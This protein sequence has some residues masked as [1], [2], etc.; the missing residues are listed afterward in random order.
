[1]CFLGFRRL[2]VPGN[3]RYFFRIYTETIYEFLAVF[4]GHQKAKTAETKIKKQNKTKQKK[5]DLLNL[6]L[7]EIIFN[8][9]GEVAMR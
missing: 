8:A 9:I 1:M 4:S 6:N 7:I 3:F 2:K 5:S